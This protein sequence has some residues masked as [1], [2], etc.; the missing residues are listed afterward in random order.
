MRSILPCTSHATPHIA[1]THTRRVSG[2]GGLLSAHSPFSAIPCAPSAHSPGRRRRGR[3]RVDTLCRA[4]PQSRAVTR[5]RVVDR[6]PRRSVVCRELGTGVI[7]ALGYSPPFPFVI[8]RFDCASF[9]FLAM[10]GRWAM[11]CRDGRLRR[12]SCLCW[13]SSHV[14]SA[15][16]DPT[17]RVALSHVPRGGPH[18]ARATSTETPMTQTARVASLLPS[19]V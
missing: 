15:P 14:R 18:A 10:P 5:V 7:T 19:R 12:L 9:S 13:L 1:H 8:R 16:V 11:A 3:R 17:A 6:R 4:D 2:S